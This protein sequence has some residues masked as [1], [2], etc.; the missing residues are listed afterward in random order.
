MKQTEGVSQK[1]PTHKQE[2]RRQILHYKAKTLKITREA[3]REDKTTWKEK[4]II[5][6]LQ[7]HSWKI[8]CIL[9]GSVL[10]TRK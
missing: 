1:R 6:I 9:R 4:L 3:L 10:L 5:Y 2:E 8:Y 7:K